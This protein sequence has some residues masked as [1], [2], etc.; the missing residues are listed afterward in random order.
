MHISG[1]HFY[2][3]ELTGYVST[4]SKKENTTSGYQIIFWVK[5][6][7]LTSA[8]VFRFP[9]KTYVTALL[10]KLIEKVHDTDKKQIFQSEIVF[11]KILNQH[12]SSLFLIKLH[13]W[14]IH[15][16]KKTPKLRKL[17]ESWLWCQ[18]NWQA[19]SRSILFQ[20]FPK[21]GKPDCY[22]CNQAR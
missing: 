17:L 12:T 1:L 2:I 16:G 6:G 21:A 3:S 14:L 22:C 9:P 11:K 19:G 8:G 10:K 15:W 18:L 4:C 20:L 7:F 13:V 5:W